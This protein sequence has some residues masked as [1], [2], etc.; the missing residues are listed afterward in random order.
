MKILSNNDD[1]NDTIVYLAGFTQ[2]T[3]GP[4]SVIVSLNVLVPSYSNLI[5]IFISYNSLSKK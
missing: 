3:R 4:F 2:E 5:I 1:D